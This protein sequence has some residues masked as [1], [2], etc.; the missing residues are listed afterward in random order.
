MPI[1]FLPFFIASIDAALIA[2]LMPGAGPPPTI[3]A[4][5]SFLLFIVLLLRHKSAFQL[6][7]QLGHCGIFKV[8]KPEPVRLK[9]AMRPHV[10]G[11]LI[12][13]FP[14]LIKGRIVKQVPR[15]D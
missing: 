2:P 6:F 13:L 10:I 8:V 12:G 3:M 9:R 14:Y 15:S 7:H 1:T 5:V 11:Y 4:M